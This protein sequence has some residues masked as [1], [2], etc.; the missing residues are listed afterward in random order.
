[1]VLVGVTSLKTLNKSESADNQ[2]QSLN[3]DY[4]TSKYH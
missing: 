1:M 3:I 4:S 2:T